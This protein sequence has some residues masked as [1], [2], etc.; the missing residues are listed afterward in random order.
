ME[1]MEGGWE[2][3][4]GREGEGGRGG[5]KLIKWNYMIWLCFRPF[6]PLCDLYHMTLTILNLSIFRKTLNLLGLAAIGFGISTKK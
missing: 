6:L 1:G 4:G 3:E 2:R 5:K